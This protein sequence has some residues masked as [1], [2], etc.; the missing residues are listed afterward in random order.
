MKIVIY[1]NNENSEKLYSVT[2]DSLLKLG[3]NEFIEIE[4]VSDKK[5]ADV[6]NII[7]DY[8]FCIEEDSLDFKDMIFE[9]Q[10][11]SLEEMNN[12]LISIIWWDSWSSCS[13]SCSSCSW[14]H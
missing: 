2:Q 6:L 13:W 8:A 14:C 5:Y 7:S 12:L 3:L 11:P 9:G 1:W 4:K 10:M